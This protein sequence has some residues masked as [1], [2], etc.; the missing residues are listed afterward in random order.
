V[1]MSFAILPDTMLRLLESLSRAM[2]E[3]LGSA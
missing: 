3:M 2:S 1:G